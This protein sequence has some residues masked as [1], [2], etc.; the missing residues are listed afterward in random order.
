VDASRILRLSLFCL[1]LAAAPGAPAVAANPADD[2][3]AKAAAWNERLAYAGALITAGK[4]DEAKTILVPALSEPCPATRVRALKLLQGALADEASVSWHRR[5]WTLLQPKLADYVAYPF[6]LAV[7][8]LLALLG[9]GGTRWWNRRTVEVKP[10]AVSNGGGFEG[11][12]FTAIAQE[13]GYKLRLLQAGIGKLEGTS[14]IEVTMLFDHAT[15][16]EDLV[17]V[18]PDER[19]G[20]ILAAVVKFLRRPRY[21]CTG[22]AYFSGPKVYLVLRLDKGGEAIGMWERVASKASL[23]DDLKD[24]SYLSFVT[25][26]SAAQR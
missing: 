16:V 11:Q 9:W 18:L 14:K 7:L 10:L 19:T 21:V 25:L 13:M 2:P 23:I 26:N 15:L 20:R 24:L 6:W 1:V 17:A 4:E 12:Y 22:S 3:C 8:L 5:Y